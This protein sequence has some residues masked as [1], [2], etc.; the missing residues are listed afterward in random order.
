MTYI[1]TGPGDTPATPLQRETEHWSIAG[2][3]GIDFTERLTLTLE[4]RYL[5][6]TIEYAGRAEDVSF[7]S[8]FGDDPNFG[9]A[10]GPGQMTENKVEE[11]EFV[12][13]VTLDWAFTDDQMLYAYAA[14]GFKPGGVSTVDANGDVSTGEYD[15]EEIWAYEIGYKSMWRDNSVRFNAA[16]FYYDYTDQQVPYFFTDPVSGL[17]NTTVL[18]AGETEIKGAEFELV[19]NSIFVDGLSVTMSYVYSDAEYTDFNTREILAEAG[20]QPDAASLALAGN[21]DGD[22]S[23]NQVMNSPEHAGLISARY[24][25][26]LGS[27]GVMGYVE[28]M[29]NYQSKRYVDLGNRAWVPSRWTSDLFAGFSGEKWDATLYVMNLFDDDEPESGLSN[30]DYGLLPDAQN[31]SSATNLVLPMPRTVGLRASYR[32]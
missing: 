9:F 32:F 20:G 16:A 26:D 15:S 12:P 11:T 24:D 5:D 8:L 25:Y 28:L 2:S 18:N 1:A 4:G 19:W 13:R 27:T 30:V 14:N 7:Y 23:G 10:F 21:A 6:E 3:V 31:V 17:L 29:G 22:F